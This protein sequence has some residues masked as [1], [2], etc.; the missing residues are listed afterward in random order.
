M[1][2]GVGLGA[3]SNVESGCA[4]SFGSAIVCTGT[5]Q[6]LYSDRVD[7]LAVLGATL[8]CRTGMVRGERGEEHD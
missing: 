3:G 8:G 6:E 7:D 1:G 4:S 5:G 2:S